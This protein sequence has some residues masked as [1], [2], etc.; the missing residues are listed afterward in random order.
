MEGQ[1]GSHNL[2]IDLNV[3]PRDG[4]NLSA[5]SVKIPDVP[6]TIH[7]CM[8]MYTL[9]HKLVHRTAAYCMEYITI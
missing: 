7:L 4:G 9:F 8:D 6:C 5:A 1:P 3:E 2:T